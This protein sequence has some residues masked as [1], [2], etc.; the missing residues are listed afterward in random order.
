L[1]VKLHGGNEETKFSS[2]RTAMN[3]QL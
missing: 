3:F 1:I 2:A